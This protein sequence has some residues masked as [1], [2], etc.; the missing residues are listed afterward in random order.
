MTDFG[1]LKGKD[2]H[3]P[4]PDEPDKEGNYPIFG[5]FVKNH[6]GY[7]RDK[8]DRDKI[9]V[10][11]MP[12]SRLQMTYIEHMYALE[13]EL[14]RTNAPVKAG[15]GTYTDRNAGKPRPNNGENNLS[16]KK[17]NFAGGY[18]NNSKSNKPVVEVNV[19]SV[20]RSN[21]TIEFTVNGLRS[22]VY[23]DKLNGRTYKVGDTVKVRLIRDD[24][25]DKKGRYALY[26]LAE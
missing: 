1:L 6:S 3:Y 8:R 5:W 17:N 7:K 14:R 2:V 22:R 26:K 19:E 11:N 13:P 25:S 9:E 15:S 24:L 10:I 21:G 12:N 23:G 4:M 16:G 20:W 18:K